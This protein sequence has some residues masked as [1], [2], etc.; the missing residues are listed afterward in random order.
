MPCT[1][2]GPTRLSVRTPPFNGNMGTYSFFVSHDDKRFIDTKIAQRFY[3]YVSRTLAQTCQK[4][5]YISNFSNW[6]REQCAQDVRMS[7]RRVIK[8]TEME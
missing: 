3:M 5:G 6:L 7:E 4:H 1:P 8:K 2:A